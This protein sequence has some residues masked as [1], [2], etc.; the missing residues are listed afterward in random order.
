MKKLLTILAI[1]GLLATAGVQADSSSSGIQAFQKGQYQTALRM[2]VNEADSGSTE[3]LYALGL[4]HEYGLGVQPSRSLAASYYFKGA[5]INSA[6]HQAVQARVFV[7][8]LE[9]TSN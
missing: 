9:R 3:A 2:L 4:M 6:R 8:A 7:E 1:S 5:K